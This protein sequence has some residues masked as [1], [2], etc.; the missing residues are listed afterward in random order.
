MDVNFTTIE[1]YTQGAGGGRK[2]KRGKGPSYGSMVDTRREL[3]FIRWCNFFILRHT[4]IPY[5]I[6]LVAVRGGGGKGKNERIGYT[7]CKPFTR[8]ISRPNLCKGH[9]VTLATEKII[10]IP[11]G[12]V[13]DNVRLGWGK[14]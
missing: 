10:R 13:S 12:G 8:R 9:S 4:E 7:N 11:I 3:V 6:S 2:E 14:L 1:D 5:S